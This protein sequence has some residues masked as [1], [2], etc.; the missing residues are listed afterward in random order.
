MARNRGP[1]STGGAA[2][3]ARAPSENTR[4]AD[5]VAPPSALA[6]LR[7]VWGKRHLLDQREREIISGALNRLHSGPLSERQE[8]AAVAIGKS[9]GVGYDDPAFDS[10]S[11]VP[12][13]NPWGPRPL[14]PPGRAA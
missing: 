11:R 4:S 1:N 13:P 5:F 8:A 3:I 7:A 6:L 9:V 14:K 12:A 2:R 10:P